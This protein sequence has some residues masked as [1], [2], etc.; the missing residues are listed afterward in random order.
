MKDY[1]WYKA[2]MEDLA[3]SEREKQKL[4]EQGQFRI[5]LNFKDSM[6][7]GTKRLQMCKDIVRA[8]IGKIRVL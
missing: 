2:K 1:E 3:E 8:R 6:Q 5:K 4:R 7:K